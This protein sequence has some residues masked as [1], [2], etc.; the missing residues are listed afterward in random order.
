MDITAKRSAI[1]LGILA[2]TASVTATLS[3]CTSTPSPQQNQSS[4]LSNGALK[5][6]GAVFHFCMRAFTNS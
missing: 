6:Y 2:L 3:S 1:R 4:G 5:L